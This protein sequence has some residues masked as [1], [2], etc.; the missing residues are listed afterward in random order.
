MLSLGLLLFANQGVRW[1]SFLYPALC[2]GAGPAL[3]ALWRRGRA[4]STLAIGLVVFL[5]WYGL[6]FWV[7]QIRDYLH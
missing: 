4:A 1:Q 7:V 2:L 3:A 5:F 6:A